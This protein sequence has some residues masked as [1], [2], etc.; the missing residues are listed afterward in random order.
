M[1]RDFTFTKNG[2]YMRSVTKNY[3]TG[4]DLDKLV[5]IQTEFEDLPKDSPDLLSITTFRNLPLSRLVPR[6]TVKETAKKAKVSVGTLF[7]LLSL[8]SSPFRTRSGSNGSYREVALK[9]A[10]YFHMLPEDLFPKSLYQ[11]NLPRQIEKA[12]RSVEILP[13]L[14]ARQQGLLSER[15]EENITDKISQDE[16]KAALIPV[17]QTLSPRLE[18]VIKLYFGLDGGEEY[19]F[20]ELGETFGCSEANARLLLY[21]ALR[22]LRH[23]ARSRALYGFLEENRDYE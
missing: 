16:L 21:K 12:F 2:D 22:K 9:L 20:K 18:K 7:N 11:L 8:R 13:M 23:P 3:S 6:G 10:D 15:T 1:E 14:E 17:L 4:N 5:K 19:S